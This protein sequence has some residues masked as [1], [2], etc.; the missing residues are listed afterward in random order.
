MS[1]T[2]DTIDQDEA[3]QK[4]VSG[5]DVFVSLPTGSGKSGKSLC[6]A[7]ASLLFDKLKQECN[8]ITVVLSHHHHTSR[9]HERSDNKFTSR[10]TNAAYVSSE[11]EDERLYG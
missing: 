5:R 9:S 8:S 7:C 6:F 11:Q 2:L 1:K 4:F 10:G 3:L